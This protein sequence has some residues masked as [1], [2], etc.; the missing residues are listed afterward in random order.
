MEDERTQ[1]RVGVCPEHGT[2]RAVREVPRMHFP[3]VVWLVRRAATPF[4]AYRCSECDT[5]VRLRKP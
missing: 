1:V 3:F 4:Q 2:V 5:K